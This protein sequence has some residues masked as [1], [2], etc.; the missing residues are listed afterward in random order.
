MD[1]MDTLYCTI[2]FVG[3]RAALVIYYYIIS[4]LKRYLDSTTALRLP[5]Q[6]QYNCPFKHDLSELGTSTTGVMKKGLIGKGL[7]YSLNSQ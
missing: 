4:Y 7:T 5:L 2:R 1:T 3:F 6:V